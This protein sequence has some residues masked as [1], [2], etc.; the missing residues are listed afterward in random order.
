M[1]EYIF[2]ESESLMLVDRDRSTDVHPEYHQLVCLHVQQHQSL[3]CS[4]SDM[5]RKPQPSEALPS[6]HQRGSIS[7]SLLKV[8]LCFRKKGELV[9]KAFP[10]YC[11]SR[12]KFLVTS[13]YC[14]SLCCFCLAF[15]LRKG[16]ILFHCCDRFC[17][18]GWVS[19]Q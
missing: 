6:S 7:D 10:L 11:N 14:C 12:G 8:P 16:Y 19:S 4:I 15:Y 2:H 17:R 9:Q 1:L 5:R 13:Y 3:F 18:R